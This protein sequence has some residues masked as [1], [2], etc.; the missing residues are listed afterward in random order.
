MPNIVC[1]PLEIKY[2]DVAPPEL[3]CPKCGGTCSPTLT[4]G[5]PRDLLFLL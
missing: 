5:S 1:V 3:P 4:G 2:Q